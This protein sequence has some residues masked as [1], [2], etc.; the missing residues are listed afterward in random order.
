MRP[1]NVDGT[2]QTPFAPYQYEN[3]F[4]ESNPA[5]GTWFVPHDIKGLA[6]LMGGEAVLIERLDRDFLVAEKQG[7]TSGTAHADETIESLRRAPINYG[8]QPSMQT[9]FI[10]SA[11][12]APWK[13]QKWSRR[14]VDAVYSHLSPERGYNGDE[15]QGLMGALAVLMKIG[16]FQLTGGVEEDPVYYIGSPIFDEITLSLDNDYFKG[17]QFTI[18]TLGNGPDSVFV[19][20]ATLNGEALNRAYLLH[21]EITNGGELVLQMSSTPNPSWR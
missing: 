8:N 1:R 17:K 2:W 7:F 11:A 19:E 20:S 21:S 14:V 6:E 10:F 5:Q 15:D 13:T 3:G 9:A 4:V 12:G 18:K 16:L